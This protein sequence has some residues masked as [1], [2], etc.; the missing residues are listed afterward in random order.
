LI[1]IFGM[2]KIVL[3]V[4]FMLLMAGDSFG[5]AFSW[6][7]GNGASNQDITRTVGTDAQNNVYQVIF[8]SG[9]LTLDSAGTPKV[10]GNYGLRDIAVVKYNCS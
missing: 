10:I 5:Q 3:L 7:I 9:S 2:R 4:L 8:Y 1:K 6:G